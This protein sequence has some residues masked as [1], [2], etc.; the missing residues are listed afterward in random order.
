MITFITSLRKFILEFNEIQHKA[1]SSWHD[2]PVVYA[3]DNGSGIQKE[4]E[5]YSNIYLINGVQSAFDLGFKTSAPVLKDLLNKVLSKVTTPM[6]AIINSDV[7]IGAD[8]SI[9]IKEILGQVGYDLFLTD[10]RHDFFMLS[11]FHARKMLNDIPALIM[12][13]QHLDSWLLGWA[14]LNVKKLYF[15]EDY[16]IIKHLDHT[17][18]YKVIQEGITPASEKYNADIYNNSKEFRKSTYKWEKYILTSF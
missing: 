16:T 18:H 13:R 8:F 2:I 4:C 9:K 6:V 1:L 14:E 10:N 15:I 12:G 7:E 3:P 5:K 17:D 11:K